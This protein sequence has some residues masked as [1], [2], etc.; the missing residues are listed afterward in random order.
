MLLFREASG[1][2]AGCLSPDAT[3]Q[4]CTGFFRLVEY[5]RT[6]FIVP[7]LFGNASGLLGVD[8]KFFVGTLQAWKNEHEEDHDWTPMAPRRSF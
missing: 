4:G 7:T 3:R 8:A 5:Q 2:T 6:A 1:L